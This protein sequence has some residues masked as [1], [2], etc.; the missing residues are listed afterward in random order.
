VQ[1]G[2]IGDSVRA[3]SQG[4]CACAVLANWTDQWECLWIADGRSS[5]GWVAFLWSL[6]ARKG[7][8]SW[9]YI[10]LAHSH[11]DTLSEGVAFGLGELRSTCGSLSSNES[12][13]YIVQPLPVVDDIWS[14]V[15][16]S[17]FVDRSLSKIK[18]HVNWYHL[19]SPPERKHFPRAALWFHFCTVWI[20]RKQSENLWIGHTK[21]I[22]MVVILNTHATS[23]YGED[24][25]LLPLMYLNG[26]AS[27]FRAA[28]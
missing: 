28:I 11:W 15:S 24:V 9:S 17:I 21:E 4:C 23:N 10:F 7:H 3:S 8:R 18:Q 12:G 27:I 16:W 14:N 26:L 1:G 13:R 20:L 22:L 2:N 5:C 25:P 6:G 19:L